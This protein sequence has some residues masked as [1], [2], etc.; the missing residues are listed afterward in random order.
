MSPIHRSGLL[1]KLSKSALPVLSSSINALRLQG[2]V[3]GLET[4]T[5]MLQGK[6]AGSGWDLG[7]EI[8]AAAECIRRSDPVLMDVGANRGEWSSGMVRLFPK[9]QKVILFEPQDECVALL[10]TLDL[11]GKTIVH[12]GVG[13]ETGT[14]E[15]FVG[16]PGWAAASFYRRDETFFAD[17]EQRKITVPVFTIDD[18]MERERIDFADFVKLDIEGAELTALKGASKALAAGKIGALSLEFGSGNINSRTFFRDF[19]ELLTGFGFEIDRVLPS[20][21]RMRIVEYYEDLEYF[22]GVSN[23]VARLVRQ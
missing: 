3:R 8:R 17:V 4:G 6:G 21:R 1:G 7:A 2:L 10:E 16:A 14:R 18:V 19:W 13:D 15:F 12:G 23:Y 9:T 22:R 5:A 20:G 11:P